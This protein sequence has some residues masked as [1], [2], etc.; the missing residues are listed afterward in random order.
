MPDD[1]RTRIAKVLQERWSGPGKWDEKDDSAKRMYLSDAD[2]VIRELEEQET[3][4][5][6]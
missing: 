2:A 4:E 6:Q 1:L 3:N 5:T